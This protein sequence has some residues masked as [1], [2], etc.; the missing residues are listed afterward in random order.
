V[1]VE[2]ICPCFVSNRFCTLE[3]IL[4]GTGVELS[5]NGIVTYSEIL[6]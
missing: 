2:G 1:L 3:Q 4:A 6:T 5:L